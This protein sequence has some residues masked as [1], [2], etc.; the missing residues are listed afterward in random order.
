MRT[1]AAI[2]VAWQKDYAYLGIGI[3]QVQACDF[4][5]ALHTARTCEEPWT[6]ANLYARTAAAQARRGD[7]AGAMETAACIENVR[8]KAWAY[9]YIA[10]AEI[11]AENVQSAKEAVSFA[12][13][14]AAR[15]QDRAGEW[16]Q[17][18]AYWTIVTVLARTHDFAGAVAT[19]ASL[20]HADDKVSAY[21]RIADATAKLGDGAHAREALQLAEAAAAAIEKRESKAWAYCCIAQAHARTGDF[22]GALQRAAGIEE[23]DQRAGAYLNVAEA[24]ARAGEVEN[25]KAWVVTLKE[26]GEAVK[27][28]LGGVRGLTGE[29]EPEADLLD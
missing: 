9:S 13:P 7:F 10:Q 15:I 20:E 17:A 14:V 21:C 16:Y 22:A 5:G 27:A 24:Q 23:A 19:A 25:V 2:E 12:E 1:A 28:C 26:P 18:Q 11:E 6:K 3:A 4:A 8:W 29:E